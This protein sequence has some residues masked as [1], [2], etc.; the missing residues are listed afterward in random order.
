[1]DPRTHRVREKL[2]EAVFNRFFRRYHPIEAYRK[3]FNKR[4][5]PDKKDFRFSY[6]LD[7]QQVFHP[8]LC[9]LRLVRKIINSFPDATVIE[10][11][12]HFNNV[13]DYIWKIVTQMIEQA[14]YSKLTNRPPTEAEPHTVINPSDVTIEKRKYDDPT[15][16]LLFSLIEPT[17]HARL[18]EEEQT[19]SDVVAAEL[20]YYKSIPEQDWPK[21]ENTL[22][23]WNSSQ[24]KTTFPCMAQVA[25]AFLGCKPSA[26]HLECD[27]GTL[28][29]VLSPK[30]AA[31]GAGFVEVE[32]MLKL[33]KHLFLS[34]P[35]KVINLPNKGWEK[36]IP[37]R[38]GR[39]D[40]TC[41]DDDDEAYAS[42]NEGDTERAADITG[43]SDSGTTNGDD[44]SALE[45][46]SLSLN[47]SDPNTLDSGTRWDDSGTDEE[48]DDSQVVEATPAE[49]QWCASQLSSVTLRDE[50]E[51]C[52][53][54][55]PYCQPTK[56]LKF[57]TMK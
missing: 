31:L 8:A 17:Q 48:N 9:N 16:A 52:D 53:I 15:K 33:N 30:R 25:S 47:G 55:H 35:D 18:Q 3:E 42:S 11:E 2:R 50:E 12:R 57:A 14:A 56:W 22:Q 38:P 45:V 20:M 5:K 23:W 49:S 28:N 36:H 26:G 41:S 13:S 34:K 7:I 37:N 51:T 46:V 19:P 21:F 10:K 27:F 6:L 54:M 29:D 39:D 24:V 44:D 43:N 32:M 40:D 1:M 4:N